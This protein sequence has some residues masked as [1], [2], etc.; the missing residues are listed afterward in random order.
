MQFNIKKVR[1]F[2]KAK[3][4]YEV[5]RVLFDG[6]LNR[7]YIIWRE[8]MERAEESVA[9]MCRVFCLSKAEHKA[10]VE[11]D[12]IRFIEMMEAQDVK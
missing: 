9:P 8:Y 3:K 12:A 6:R 1:R 5:L 11:A 2:L 10:I 4:R 7:D